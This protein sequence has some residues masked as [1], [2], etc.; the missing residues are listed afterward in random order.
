MTTHLEPHDLNTYN[1][2]QHFAGNSELFDVIVFALLP[3]GSCLLHLAV[4]SFNVR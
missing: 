1:S 3:D 2:G 4:E